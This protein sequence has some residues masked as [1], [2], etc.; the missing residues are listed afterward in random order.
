[1]PAAATGAAPGCAGSAAL[2]DHQVEPL[3]LVRQLVRLVVSAGPEPGRADAGDR[4]LHGTGLCERCRARPLAGLAAGSSG[5]GGALDG[6]GPGTTRSA[7][8]VSACGIWI[9]GRS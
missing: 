1:M 3:A 4:S 8:F 5:P 2:D 9:K 6:R 7:R